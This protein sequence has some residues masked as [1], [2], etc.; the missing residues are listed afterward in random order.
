MFKLIWVCIRYFWCSGRVFG[1]LIF[2]ASAWCDCFLRKHGKHLQQLRQPRS[3]GDPG[4][5]AAVAYW[6]FD[7]HVSRRTS[8]AFRSEADSSKS[9]LST[10]HRST[11]AQLFCLIWPV[12]ASGLVYECNFDGTKLKEGTQQNFSSS[13]VPLEFVKQLPPLRT[14]SHSCIVTTDGKDRFLQVKAKT[15][16]KTNGEIVFNFRAHR[17]LDLQLK[18]LYPDQTYTNRKWN[19][20]YHTAKSA[21]VLF[22]YNRSAYFIYKILIVASCMV[23]FNFDRS[24][25]SKSTGNWSGNLLFFKGTAPNFIHKHVVFI[26]YPNNVTTEGDHW[27][28]VIKGLVMSWSIWNFNFLYVCV[29]KSRK[30]FAFVHQ[31]RSRALRER[32]C[33]TLPQL[34]S[35]P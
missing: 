4:N 26:I 14:Q 33:V 32:R 2:H 22:E 19:F 11:F 16:G 28:Y 8:S 12:L 21:L 6:S 31:V 27:W 29:L 30:S 18:Y 7:N 9:R 13:S 5:E 10:M 24:L 1:V 34:K 25:W 35:V 3:Q 15:Y 20:R 17:I 23:H